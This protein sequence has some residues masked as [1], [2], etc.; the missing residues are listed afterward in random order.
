MPQI[1]ALWRSGDVVVADHTRGDT[2]PA[3][4]ARILDAAPVRFNLAGLSMG[5]YIA[6]ELLRQARDRI[7]RLALL[8]TSAR[9]ELP[10]QTERRREQIALM[11]AGRYD[12]T[13]D[14]QF[15]LTVHPDR[16]SDPMLREIY[17]LMCEET[18][19]EVFLRHQQAIMARPDS[20]AGLAAIGCPTLVLV[21]DAD[22]LTPPPLSR[23]MAAAIPGARLV[24][25]AD[26]GHLSTLERPDAVN[27][28]LSEWI[29]M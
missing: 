15:P 8:N 25:V 17:G 20:R 27:A 19:P 14:M 16:R 21:G 3:I 23:E 22:E 2:I 18:G 5:G 26:C 7:A 13:I 4:A 11:Q 12:E 10:A 6:F 24:V 29:E 9:P 1:P 28:A